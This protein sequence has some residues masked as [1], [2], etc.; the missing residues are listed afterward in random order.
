MLLT[1]GAVAAIG[2]GVL[3]LAQSDPQGGATEDRLAVLNP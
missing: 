2:L 3:K 1:L